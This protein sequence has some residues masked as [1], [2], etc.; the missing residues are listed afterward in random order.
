MIRD[1]IWG[2]SVPI[3][4]HFLNKRYCIHFEGTLPRRGPYV[5]LPKH[6]SMLDPVLEGLLIRQ[7]GRTANFLM[8]PFIEPLDFIFKFYGGISVIR[9]KDG[10]PEDEKAYVNKSAGQIA[11]HRFEEGE[12]VVIYQE[13][14][15]KY[16]KMDAI[17]IVQN[18]PLDRLLKTG[19]PFYAVGNEYEDI[20]K[21]GSNI[22]VR[23]GPPLYTTDKHVLKA[24]LE[25]KLS[26][27]SRISRN[28]DNS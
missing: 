7:T 6:Q 10:Y 23:V 24:Y 21:K 26:T 11:V 17:N 18:S 14:T 20:N 19:G 25:E 4:E 9:A 8:R 15:R 12:P 22:W 3:V 1:F 5:L 13:K 2:C 16:K 28:T 27:L